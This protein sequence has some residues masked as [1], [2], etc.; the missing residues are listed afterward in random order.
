MW[1]PRPHVTSEELIQVSFAI[2]M[3]G[4]VKKRG[5]NVEW[6][7]SRRMIHSFDASLQIM[8]IKCV[9]Q[10]NVSEVVRKYSVCETIVWK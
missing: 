10:A 2:E 1:S 7:V 4:N 6:N 8:V 3:V 5:T 9:W